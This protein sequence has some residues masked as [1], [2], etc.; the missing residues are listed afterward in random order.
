M[1][2]EIQLGGKRA[3]GKCAI[4]DDDMYEKLSQH[5]WWCNSDGYAIRIE[6]KDGRYHKQIFMH[7][8]VLK[9]EPG[10]QVDHIN[11]NNIDNR[12]ANLRPATPSQNQANRVVLSN[13]TSGFK[14]VSFDGKSNKW[15]AYVIKDGEQ[16][17]LGFYEIREDAAKAYNVKASELFGDYAV[18]NNVNHSDFQI[19]VRKRYSRYKGVS[20]DKRHNK[21]TATIINKGKH[22]HLGRFTSE[23]DAARMYN[24][25]AK[26]LFGDEAKLNVIKEEDE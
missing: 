26:D 25:W 1:V 10:L 23:Q 20:F 3:N 24:F 8:E 12:R 19:K 7:K 5:N 6:Y 14:G 17:N 15:R 21:W 16:I 18:L 22:K 11:R 9:V 2:K 4:V 13:S